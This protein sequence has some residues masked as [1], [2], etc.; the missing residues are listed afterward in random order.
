MS[1]ELMLTM[2]KLLTALYHDPVIAI[3]TKDEIRGIGKELMDLM[4]KVDEEEELIV[5]AT[6]G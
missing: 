3:E 6:H 2:G 1:K 5:D 4:E